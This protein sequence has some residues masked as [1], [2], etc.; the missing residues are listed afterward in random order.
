MQCVTQQYMYATCLL[1]IGSHSFLLIFFITMTG[2]AMALINIYG[3]YPTD[4][5]RI[6][7]DS[8]EDIQDDALTT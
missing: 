4:T 2:F 1:Y 5:E 7:G 6:D 8:T 3:H